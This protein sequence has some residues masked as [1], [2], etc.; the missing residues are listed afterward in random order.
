MATRIL[1]SIEARL[2]FHAATLHLDETQQERARSLAVAGT[3]GALLGLT[4]AELYVLI[5][6]G[7][8]EWKRRNGATVERSEVTQ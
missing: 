3:V 2:Q 5:A 4:P 6:P 8:E 7:Y 1:D